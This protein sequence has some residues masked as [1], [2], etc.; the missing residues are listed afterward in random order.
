MPGTKGMNE[1]LETAS[2]NPKSPSLVL[3]DFDKL[4]VDDDDIGDHDQKFGTPKLDNDKWA[5]IGDDDHKFG[6]PKLTSIEIEELKVNEGEN[7]SS[8]KDKTDV[9]NKETDSGSV[10]SIETPDLYRGL[11]YCIDDTFSK[12]AG[13]I[14]SLS[15]N[16]RLEVLNGDQAVSSIKAQTIDTM[17]EH[18]NRRLMSNI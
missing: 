15:L 1:N 14:Y 17:N 8:L 13:L 16:D 10:S 18:Y 6:T 12:Y 4:N 9:D 2:I 5:K 7:E 11:V 3:D